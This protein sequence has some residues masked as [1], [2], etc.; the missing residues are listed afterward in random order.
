MGKS[1]NVTPSVALPQGGGA[2]RGMGEKFSADLFT[3]TGNLS[4]PIQ[5][6]GGRNQLQPSLSLS[7]STGHGN[8]LFGVG[9]ALSIPEIMRSTSRGL[10]RYVDTQDGF[11]LSGMEDLVPLPA[12]AGQPQQYRP[13]TEGIFARIEH[14][15]TTDDDF[16]RVTTKEGLISFYGTPR[17]H[18]TSPPTGWQDPAALRDP[19]VANKLYS[20]KLTRTQDVFG[21]RIEYLYSRDAGTDGPHHWDVPLLQEI[22]YLDYGAPAAPSFLISVL[23]EYEDRP[24]PFSGYRA[25]FEVRTRKRCKR[26]VVRV[27]G[28]TQATYSM[29]Y[30]RGENGVSQLIQV[31]RTGLDEAGTSEA[32]PPL[33][34]SYTQFQPRDRKIQQVRVP[35]LSV[36]ALLSQQYDLVDVTGKGLPDILQL[37]NGVARYWQ[38]LGDGT[39]SLPRNLDS[40][41]AGLDLGAPGVALMDCDGNGQLDLVLS[42]PTVSGVYPMRFGGSWDARAFRPFRNAPS[43]SLKDPEVKLIDLDGDGATDAIRADADSLVCFFQDSEAGWKEVRRIPRR[44]LDSFPNVSF[45]D[46][47]VRWADMSGD[48]LQDLVLIHMRT[49]EYWPARGRGSWGKRIQMQNAPRLPLHFDPRR[50][51][52]GDVD[53]DGCADLLYVEDRKL[54]LWLNQQG[55]RWS[56]PIEIHGTPSIT[57][58]DSVR[59]I[60]LLGRGVAGILWVLAPPVGQRDLFFLDLTGGSKPYLAHELD[61]HMGALTRVRYASSTQFYLQD[62]KIPSQR[63]TAPLPFPV[64]VVQSTEAIDQVSGSRLLTQYVYHHGYWD[65][66]DREFRGFGRVDQ[67]DTESFAPY[68]QQTSGF[69][70]VPDSYFSPPT[71][72]RHWFHQGPHGDEF[73]DWYEADYSAEFWADDPNVL[74]RSAAQNAFLAR[75]PRRAKRDALRAL[76]GQTLRTELFARDGSAYQDRPFTVTESL[77][78]VSDLPG[79]RPPDEKLPADASGL[80]AD[81]FRLHVFFP[82][83][84]AQRTSQWERGDE[85]L[86]TFQATR[87]YD[88]FGQAQEQIAVAVPRTRAR[89]HQDLVPGDTSPFL[90]VLT[91]TQHAYSSTAYLAGRVAA[92]R[93]YEVTNTGSIS[94]PE[95][96]AAAQALSDA[97]DA[98]MTPAAVRLIS[99]TRNYYDGPAFTGLALGQ[100]GSFG[101]LVRSE[102]LAMDEAQLS[103]AYGASVPPFLTGGS[104]PSYW[105][106]E[107]WDSVS[108]NAGYTKDGS[109]FYAQTSRTLYDFQ[110]IT[111]TTPRG[112]L[113]QSKDAQGRVT[114]A[115]Y[116]STY[117][118][119]LTQ[120]T[121]PAGLITLA[122]HDI[123]FLQPKKLTDPNGNSTTI[124]FTPLGLVQ[125]RMLQGK[126]ATEGDQT[127]PSESFTYQ[128]ATV[129]I[130]VRVT[131][132]QYHDSDTDSVIPSGRKDDVLIAQSFSDGFGRIV[133]VRTQAESLVYGTQPLATD[134]LNPD[135]TVA[136][137]TGVLTPTTNTA[138]VLVSE[139]KRYDNKGRV[140][141]TAEPYYDSGYTYQLPVQQ[142]ALVKTFYDPLGRVVRTQNADGSESRVIRGRA[143]VVALIPK[144]DVPDSFFPSPWEVWTYDA[145][146]NAGR[147][148]SAQT[149][150]INED[151][152]RG[153]AARS[154]F[155]SHVDTPSSAIIDPLGRTISATQRLSPDPSAGWFTYTSRYDLLGNLLE[156][157]DPQNRVVSSAVYDYLKRPL[158]TTSLDAGDHFVLLDAA[159]FPVYATD[160]RGALTLSKPDSAG[161]P[162]KTWARDLAAESVTLRIVLEYGDQN[163]PD[164]ATR[165]ARRNLNLLGRLMAQRDEAGLVTFGSYDFKGNGTSR[166]RRVIKDDVLLA[167]FTGLPAMGSWK[168]APY[169]VDW[170]KPM[171][172]ADLDTQTFTTDAAFDALG[173][174][175]WSLYPVPT[176]P[177]PK[178]VPSFNEAGALRSLALDGITLVEHIAYNPKGQRTLMIAAVA[179]TAGTIDKRVL[180]RYAYDSTTFRLLRMRSEFCT[181]DA[182]RNLT[183]LGN[184]LQDTGYLY[185]RAGNIWKQLERITDGGY[186]PTKDALDRLYTYDALYRL[187]SATG[188]ETESVKKPAPADVLWDAGPWD[189]K[190]GK[191]Q[192]YKEDYQYDSVGFLKELKRTSFTSSGPQVH[193]RTYSGF[194]SG[195]A[196]LNNRLASVSYPD[197]SPMPGAP[198]SVP[199]TY[200]SAGNCLSEGTERK[201]EWDHLGRLRSFRNQTSD[202]AEPTQYVQYLYDATGQRVKKLN[203]KQ[204]GKDWD[205]TTYIDGLL[206]L[207]R[208]QRTM[209]AKEGLTLHL[210]DGQKRLGRRR[211][212]ETFDKKPDHLL[213][214]GDHLG[215]A[216]VELDWEKGTLVD[217]EEFRPYGET[218]FGSYELKRYRFTGKE[219]DEESGLNYH[220]ARYYAPGLG[221]W[222]SPDPKGTVDGVN[223]YGYVR[224]NPVGLHDADGT[225][226]SEPSSNTLGITAQQLKSADSA[227]RP[228]FQVIPDDFVGPRLPNQVTQRQYDR[229]LKMY[230]TIDSEKSSIAFDRK[231][232]QN[233]VDE[234]GN[235]ISFQSFKRG[236]MKDIA[237]VLQSES[238]RDLIERIL[239]QNK[240]HGLLI[241]L[242]TRYTVLP[243][244]INRGVFQVT[245]KGQGESTIPE[246]S[247]D[248]YL[249]RTGKAGIGADAKIRY[250]PA[251]IMAK[252]PRNDVTLFH[253]LVHA[254]RDM[255]GTAP[256][257]LVPNSARLPEDRSYHGPLGWYEYQASGLSVYANE[258]LSENRYRAERAT[259]GSSQRGLPSDIGLPQRQH[260][261]DSDV[262]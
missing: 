143:P 62:E 151:R 37:G 72:T 93:A 217:R 168:V 203:R 137:V 258:K 147:D 160:P 188:R 256:R 55:E 142:G 238:G 71:E 211:I 86:V 235:T 239:T 22:R 8:G 81:D 155:L 210:M 29:T 261:I 171:A 103:A 85:P 195:T 135:V 10:P 20:W 213:I 205:A 164:A 226:A 33:S 122:E 18:V 197:P 216:N 242:N 132:R 245:D 107:H 140:V 180:T 228:M 94:V 35:N 141:E 170:A 125:Q 232:L 89:T 219:R 133:A 225:T 262:N 153:R 250:V 157:R 70:K 187:L 57:N 152:S 117:S 259:L 138:R 69:D 229:A 21:N 58:Q 66:A 241:S 253:E 206:E 208:E 24:D 248:G 223:L 163:I 61:N 42:T 96:L 145:N 191:A 220:G 115:Q 95:H 136:T 14:V 90:S 255:S 38:N 165:T 128:F 76:R 249:Q 27:N 230:A 78:G 173:R 172:D 12:I 146:D 177:R 252:L 75:L 139:Y 23:F 129:P 243:S 106:Q 123:H 260:Y 60:D 19:D 1:Q 234:N 3:G 101:A 91:R 34:L 40:V 82:F 251:G 237:L 186:S 196:Q 150:D 13:R 189:D 56:D 154:S 244:N 11:I 74:R 114:I 84:I 175:K 202:S 46:P 240:G 233:A 97:L 134:I 119:F 105:P 44:A 47:H 209:A 80:P 32:L 51:L 54:T 15:R 149:L 257:W 166:S 204:K 2:M 111:V 169:R 190:I 194:L 4:I 48:G 161:R 131:K 176:G 109:K 215:S 9:W 39:F 179:K 113:L 236:F 199:Y 167:V 5:V 218:S 16:W 118:F 7:Y 59:L 52:L 144:L 68:Y 148:L 110:D 41:P 116:D 53:G 98:G 31:Q 104:K 92:V 17:A 178:L 127:Q 120:I 227:L 183:P 65:G 156:H 222:M 63:W 108:P 126:T 87:K 247:T 79:T 221:R 207:R 198:L 64:Q 201:Y 246:D 174:I 224:G 100:L 181:A 36:G 28:K 26:L 102:Q 124:T 214:L 184:P 99:E 121:D 193:T 30:G 73:G 50:V 185:D 130:S 6:P 192:G 231:S 43:F 25:G 83:S 88:A 67:R 158:K 254:Y 77:H 162:Q 49:V 212:N 182:S 159:A 112:L 45:S 200:D